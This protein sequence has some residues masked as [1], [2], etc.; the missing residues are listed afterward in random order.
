MRGSFNYD[1]GIGG[2]ISYSYDGITWYS[3]NAN[4]FMNDC[5]SITGNDTIYV[6]TGNENNS[7]ANLYSIIYSY[8]GI[9]WVGVTDKLTLINEGFSVVWN[10]SIFVCVGTQ[11][12]DPGA[13]NI[14]KSVD[15]IN[16]TSCISPSSLV[17]W[18]IK[19]T[20]KLWIISVRASTTDRSYTFYTSPDLITWST[21][22]YSSYH[23]VTSIAVKYTVPQQ[24]KG[25]NLF[26]ST[27]SLYR[28]YGS[29][30]T[31]FSNL[32]V[33]K[34]CYGQTTVGADSTVDITN[35]PYT[36]TSTY[37]AI[38]QVSDVPTTYSYGQ[39]L[40]LSASSIRLYNQ[41]SAKAH[42]VMWKT[43]GY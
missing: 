25:L 19:W 5:Y 41:N 32:K 10:G 3:T 42:T 20:N 43:I 28:Y 40:K 39:A 17:I 37:F 29:S 6:A 11:G 30:T 38:A 2:A 14:V 33:P 15:G 31:T 35:L 16:W 24:F 12:S 22:N 7:D 27:N 18:D 9:T 21:I 26:S 34:I 4:T 13:T 36:S 23:Y 1:G 8:D